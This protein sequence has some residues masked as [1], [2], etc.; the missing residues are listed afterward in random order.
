M[1]ATTVGEIARPAHV[2]GAGERCDRL[3]EIF[4][5]RPTLRCVVVADGERLGLLM[6]DRFGLVMSGPYG[7]GRALWGGRPVRDLVDWAPLRV[8]AGT[9][10]VAAAHRVRARA[11]D[12]R[13][14]DV[15]VDLGDGTVG[16]TSAARLLDTLARQFAHRAVHDELTGLVNRS[17]FL[18][19][20]TAACADT[21][22]DRVLLAIVDL[23]GMKRI[24]DSYGHQVGDAV[25][26]MVARRL[27][28]A[29]R[30][31]EVVARLGA[32]EFVV[33]ARVPRTAAVEREA[34]ELGQR[35]RLAVAARDGRIDPG[36]HPR[37]SVGVAV[38]GRVADPTTLLSEADMAMF[39][40]KQAGGDQVAV[41]V[42]V[43]ADLALDVDRVDRSV[44]QA[45]RH[46]ELRMWYQPIVR[47]PDLE[48]VGVEA[49]VR[50]VHPHRGL[51]TPDRF[52]PG[53]RRAGHLLALD[54]WVLDR[55]CRDYRALLDA[56]GERAPAT[57][58]VN[59]S[60]PTLATGFDELV[61][62][63]LADAGLAPDRLRLELPEDA[64]LDT[65]TAAAPR[66]DR[67]RRQ[68]VDLTLDDMGAGSTSL[69]HLSKVAI[70]GLKIDAAFVAGMLHNPRDHTVV[71][72]L[73]DLGHGLGLPVTAEG[74]ETPE[75]VVALA[76]LGVG[77]AQGYHLGR[78]Q[79]LE[80]LIGL[81]AAAPTG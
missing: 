18:D 48:V 3:D 80:E 57:L 58:S 66:L 43:A 15:L 23:D 37:A 30:P 19:L 52:L 78:P 34:T 27:A 14:D 25:L 73:A 61:E 38:C 51:L 79:P 41:T 10:V 4:R 1:L 16:R 9:T 39:R 21:D 47:L 35:C 44:A 70:G 26:V 55:A 36:A 59:L 72:L 32:D 42:D 71:K 63:V 68:G 75:Q 20:L 54:R 2:I 11:V 6:R 53:A 60:P 31:G 24:N 76:E 74:V 45:I 33:L 62:G 64:D 8:P 77:F 69:R 50:W 7:Y 13:Y 17:H 67:L 29:G 49:L 40:A 22:R 12:R 46:A 28:A 65:L 81:L 56:L 5:S